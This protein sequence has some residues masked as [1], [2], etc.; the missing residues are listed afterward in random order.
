M[1]KSVETLVQELIDASQGHDWFFEY[2]DDYSTWS[3]GNEQR[4]RISHAFAALDEVD[5]KVSV[6]TWNRVAP[7]RFHFRPLAIL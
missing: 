5:P 3:R 1:E 4:T 7:A 6:E 2:A